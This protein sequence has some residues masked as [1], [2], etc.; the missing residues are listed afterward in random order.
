ML[1][2]NEDI[3]NLGISEELGICFYIFKIFILSKL[4]ATHGARTH[5]PRDQ[6]SH[7]LPTEQARHPKSWVEEFGG[8][9]GFGKLVNLFGLGDF[10]LA[11]VTIW[12]NIRNYFL[13]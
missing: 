12:T 9:V 11:L 5:D 3:L 7:V 4:Y 8:F 13:F 6:E 10:F 1:P 2:K